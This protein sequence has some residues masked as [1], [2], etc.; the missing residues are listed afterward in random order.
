MLNDQLQVNVF[1]NV[2]L[3]F[4]KSLV[5]YEAFM[6]TACFLS[7]GGLCLWHARLIHNGQTSIEAHINKSEAKRMAEMGKIYKNPYDFGPRYNWHLFL[8]IEY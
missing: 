6:S 3:F 8:G 4:R 5:F 7:L 1:K 2:R